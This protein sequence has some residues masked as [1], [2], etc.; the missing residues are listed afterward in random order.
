MDARSRSR[1]L[2]GEQLLVL[3]HLLLMHLLQEQ[4]GAIERTIRHV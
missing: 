3:I 1:L 4:R 2:I